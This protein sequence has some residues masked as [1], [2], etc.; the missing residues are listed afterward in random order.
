[1]A[2]GL[3]GAPPE[4]GDPLDEREESFDVTS[5]KLDRQIRAKAVELGKNPEDASDYADAM[6]ALNITI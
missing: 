6:R 2:T 5:V 1:M 4:F 3:D